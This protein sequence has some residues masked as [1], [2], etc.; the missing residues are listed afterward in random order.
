MSLVL[1]TGV[2]GFLAAHVLDALLANPAGYRVRGT[3]RSLSKKDALL[4]RL[5]PADRERVELVVVEDTASSDL[6]EALQGVEYVAHV[7]SPYQ[8]V[9][10]GA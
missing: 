10:Y 3:L 8:L 6:T 2:T 1:L 7:A 9:S 4:A 5:A